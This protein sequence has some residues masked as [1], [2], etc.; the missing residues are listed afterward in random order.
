L[1]SRTIPAAEAVAQSLTSAEVLLGAGAQQL[2]FKYCSTFDSTNEGNIG[3]V[4]EALLAL[5]GERRT[6]ACPAFPANR[7]TV[8]QGHL[9]VGNVLLSESS[10]RDHPLTP[11]RDANLVRVLQAQTRLTVSLIAHE[12][13]RAGIDAIASAFDKLDGIAIVDAIDDTDLRAIGAAAKSLK[14]VTGGSGVAMGLPAN[15]RAAGLLGPLA[16]PAQIRAP[17]GR[18]VILA[19][20]CSAATRR[21]VAA[22]MAAGHPALQV[23]ALAIAGGRLTSEDVVNFVAA[24]QGTRAPLVYSSADPTVVAAVQEK[25]GTAKAGAVVEDLLGAVAARLASSGFSRFLVAGGETSGAVVAALGVKALE[26]GAEIDPGV[27][28]TLSTGARPLA[29][30]LKSGNFGTDDFFVKA[31]DAIQ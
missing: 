29:L 28:W 12:T 27:P 25:L 4:A 20:S 16:A 3:P 18:A 31:W 2:F 30:A 23:D 10:M 8:Y 21:Q 9:F 22:A 19:G 11:M 7:R 13:V 17:V 6:L 14:L 15:F 24:A 26:I 5:V 1:K